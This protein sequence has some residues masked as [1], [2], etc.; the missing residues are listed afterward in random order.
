MW[1][2]DVPLA[3]AIGSLLNIFLILLDGSAAIAIAAEELRPSCEA[4]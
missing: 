4:I 3:F 2:V 1:R